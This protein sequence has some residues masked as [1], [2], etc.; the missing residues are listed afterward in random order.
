LSGLELGKEGGRRGARCEVNAR[1]QTFGGFAITVATGS[2]II[3]G[4]G[5]S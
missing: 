5:K 2:N 3:A 4:P 1:A